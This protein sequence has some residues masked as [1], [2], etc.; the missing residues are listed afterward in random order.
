MKKKFFILFLS[1]ISAVC[2]AVGLSACD[3]MGGNSSDG[4]KHEHSLV[5]Y[6]AVDATET[7]DGHIEYWYCSGCGKF[8][9]DAE[10]NNEINAESIIIAA[11]G[12]NTTYTITFVADG[13]IVN[14][15]TY[16]KSDT[17]I[18][19]PEVPAKDGYDGTWNSFELYTGNI[20]VNAV[21][22]V[23]TYYV[24]Y[25]NTKSAS[26]SNPS[27]YTI[28]DGTIT[29]N[30]LYLDGYTFNGWYTEDGE[31][32]IEI[33]Y[34]D[35]NNGITL[36]A[37]WSLIEYT[38]TFVD[39]NGDTIATRTYTVETEYITV[40][41]VPEKSGYAGVWENYNLTVGGIT[42]SPVY[43]ANAYTATFVNENGNAIY[44]ATYTVENDS[45][46]EPSVPDKQGYTGVWQSYSLDIGGIT[47][48]PVYTAIKYNV[49]FV[50]DDET[51]D[52]V[53]YTV[54]DETI[55]EPQIPTKEG[56]DGEWENYTLTYGV[57][58]TVAALY[59]SE[60]ATEGLLYY[61]V[62]NSDEPYYQIYGYEGENIDVVVPAVYRNFT[63]K[64]IRNSAFKDC[65]SVT[66]I[67]IPDS[68]TEI[69]QKAFYN[70][71]SLESIVLP[72]G[73]TTID[74]YVFYNCTS[75]ESIAIPDS[76]TSIGNYVFCYCWAL[77]EIN[78]NATAMDDL[79]SN[80]YVFGYAG[81][82]GDGITVTI[83]AKVTKIPA[84]L[85]YPY[86]SGSYAPN[87]TSVVFEDGSVCTSIGNYAFW[88][89]TSLTSITIPDSITSI[90]SDAFY[91]CKSLENVYYSGITPQWASISFGSSTANP[92]Y[93]AD[94]LYLNGTLLTD[95]KDTDITSISAYAF[96]G[97]NVTS[98][99]I[100]DGVTSIGN[101][102]F[103]NCTSLTS[104]Y[105]SGTASQ[106]ASISFG[107]STANP[108][109]YAGNLYLNGTL[110]TDLKDTDI[111]SI[112][113][114]A[115]AGWNVT[116]ITIPD[117]VTSIGNGAFY[118]CTSL[119]SV[120]YS[121]TASQLA[122]ISFGNS[123]A[124][125]LYY[126]GNLYLNGTLL[127]DLKDTDITS[128]SA[129]AFAGWNVTSITIP[130]SVTSI[131][132]SVFYGC[133]SLTSITIPDSVT[134]IGSW[135]FYGCTSLER[136]TIGEAVETIGDRAFYNCTSLTS[137]EIPDSITAIGRG[138]FYDCDSL[139]SVTIGEAVETIGSYAF[140]RCTALTSITIPDVVTS[141]GSYAFGYCSSLTSV[142]VGN[143]VE[144]IGE[145]AFCY[146]SSLTSV[147]IGSGVTSIGERAFYYCRALTEI[148][149][150][151]TAMDDLSL[152]NYVFYCA[153][154]NGDGIT[155]TI[156]AKVTKIPA[157]LFYPHSS[158]SYV[159]NIISVVFEDNSACTS[160]GSYAFR[161]CTSLTSVTI[162]DSVTSIGSGAFQYCTSLASITIP[163]GVTSIGN[164]AFNGCTSLERVTIGEA[165]ETIGDRAFYDC[166][167]LTSVTIGDS[168]T[169]IGE[170]AFYDT[171]YYNDSNNW[172]DNVLYIGIYLIKAN[173]SISGS[174]EI[175]DETA[176]IADS[177][178]ADCTSLTSI[179][180][181]DSVTSIGNY[182]FFN[183]TS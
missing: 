116:S 160:I 68:I 7:E 28:E 92:L 76:V 27:Q 88:Y 40:P 173:T 62:S 30:D 170:H 42:V 91:Y 162:G 122:S 83:G 182:T 166:T 172:T 52:T 111:T 126:A 20:T 99:T 105:Y 85:F 124:N 130:D 157:Y 108:L 14:E 36:V 26:N 148:N 57:D 32:V 87:I 181:P 70:C 143:S 132:S 94:N 133:T 59:T 136:V 138:A 96:A 169:S 16:S 13:N 6:S 118:N 37:D 5:Y 90:R 48:S 104:V 8:F 163:D 75:L 179:T 110:L 134:S 139:E 63:V 80:N 21:Y 9:S 93:Y 161:Y 43:T 81:Q 175:K 58:I 135:A 140:W 97:W 174:Y 144:T 35:Y 66:S 77:T 51:V 159:P 33:S 121:G 46:Y 10:G 4:S 22:T 125:P 171:A 127:T 123:T 84:Y 155:V 18:E 103:Y 109:Y 15:I 150:N 34:N 60:G 178:F 55:A 115:F 129:Y 69:G 89:C 158:S 151:A 95:L 23:I 47:I 12:E 78:F 41:E 11:L 86:S 2:L 117:G 50:A 53:T 106:L 120:Y 98:I 82:N 183:C 153:G 154:Q 142:T 3:S 17:N 38:A 113:A 74:W 49:I 164:G 141:I 176:I 146:C 64:E 102:A 65:T 145:R 180:I 67:E 147:T 152:N 128:I 177:A 107:N 56:F 72:E 31:K 29:L 119:T 137:I 25:D 54:E 71:T 100:P 19:I 44:Y 45:I 101:G 79:S 73:I 156:G 61:Y 24:N 39:E 167:S 168:V 131:G 149:F 114:Y 165:V 112:S 1:V